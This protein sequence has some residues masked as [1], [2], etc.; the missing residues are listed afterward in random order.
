RVDIAALETATVEVD[1]DAPFARRLAA[2]LSL[3]FASRSGPWLRILMP[4]AL[5]AAVYVPLRKGLDEVAWQIGARNQVQRAIASLP[6]RVVESRVKVER[7]G[8]E[9]DI[10]LLG[11][12][13]D[14]KSA[15]LRLRDQ[16]GAA[17]G[18]LPRIDV[19]AVP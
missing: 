8:I 12:Q 11:G 15:E 18:V 5:L 19:F 2:R 4:L 6:G 1:G 7:G 17:T 3:L 9:L 13:D 14:A 10:F 16:L